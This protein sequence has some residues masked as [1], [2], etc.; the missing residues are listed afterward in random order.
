MSSTAVNDHAGART[1]VSALVAVVLVI[2]TLIALTPVFY[3]LPEAVLGAIVIHAVLRLMKI[4]QMRSFYKCHRGEFFLAMVALL[5]VVV[6]NLLSGLLLGVL[7][8]LFRVIWRSGHLHV[9][10]LGRLPGRNELYTSIDRIP[11]CKQIPGLI[12]L[13][14]DGPVFFVNSGQL[15]DEMQ[16][17]IDREEPVNAILL[18]LGSNT[19]MDMTSVDVIASVMEE[20]RAKGI[21]MGFANLSESVKMTFRCC[22]LMETLGEERAHFTVHDGVEDYLGRNPRVD[23]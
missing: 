14:L 8:S 4:R 2:G 16:A 1:Q 18:D 21:E 10:V 7:L 5:G 23:A 13:R 20:A 12:I 15:L 17:V 22:G 19:E 11:E 6:I 9:S 3:S